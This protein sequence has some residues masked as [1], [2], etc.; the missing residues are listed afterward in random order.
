[1]Q[2][3]SFLGLALPLVNELHAKVLIHD[4]AHYNP[5]NSPL[6]FL[7][8]DV[9]LPWLEKE[10][11][12]IEELY[13]RTDNGIDLLLVHSFACPPSRFYPLS[14]T[15]LPHSELTAAAVKALLRPIPSGIHWRPVGTD[16]ESLLYGIWTWEL[17]TYDPPQ[18][19]VPVPFYYGQGEYF[20]VLLSLVCD[21]CC[22][23]LSPSVCVRVLSAWL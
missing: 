20:S 6:V 7:S 13:Q 21:I 4:P 19:P 22:L 17:D 12:A 9:V 2:V 16:N 3:G 5:R 8:D 10:R 15:H 23:S 1:V 14:I 11:A 18:F